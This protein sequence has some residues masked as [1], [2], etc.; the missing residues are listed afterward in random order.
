M[1]LSLFLFISISWFLASAS[2]TSKKSTC[3]EWSIIRS[4]GI[5]GC[6]SSGDFPAFTIIS[7]IAA[8]STTAGT[9]VK[10]CISILATLKGMS[11]STGFL[12]F[13]PASDATSSS[14]ISLPSRFL[15]SDSSTTL[16][17][18]GNTDRSLPR[19]L[20]SSGMEKYFIVFPF[21]SKD[22]VIAGENSASMCL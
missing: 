18:K 4:V 17:E 5:I 6:I 19:R 1:Y 16:I 22:V 8:R 7:L 2:G 9:P 3:T 20:P 12:A 14:V 15:S 11:L 10:S 13:Q 21:K